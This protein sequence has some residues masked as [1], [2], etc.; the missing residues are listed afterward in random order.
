MSVFTDLASSFGA[1]VDPKNR[2]FDIKSGHGF[3][4]TETLSRLSV[5]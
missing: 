1:I 5:A 2:V 4:C 3:A